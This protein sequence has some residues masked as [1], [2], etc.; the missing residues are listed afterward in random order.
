MAP[1]GQRADE[2]E[3]QDDDQ[4]DSHAILLLSFFPF[5]P[6]SPLK[7][8]PDVL[9]TAHALFFYQTGALFLHKQPRNFCNNKPESFSISSC[10]WPFIRSFIRMT[11]RIMKV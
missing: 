1:S 10:L 11:T 3:D 2:Q 7:R 9:G 4:D 8:F 6:L 5:Q